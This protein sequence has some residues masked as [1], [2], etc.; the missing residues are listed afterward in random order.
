ML[1]CGSLSSFFKKVREQIDQLEWQNNWK[2]N[3]KDN[4]E[5]CTKMRVT[6]PYI[7]GFQR[8]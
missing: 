2:I 1:A 7:G 5:K 3:K 6:L 8:P 4:K